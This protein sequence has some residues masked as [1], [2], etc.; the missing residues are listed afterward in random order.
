MI[1]YMDWIFWQNIFDNSTTML[2]TIQQCNYNG[3]ELTAIFSLLFLPCV[4]H[5]YLK[6]I[7]DT[8]VFS[9]SCVQHQKVKVP[10]FYTNSLSVVI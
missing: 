6:C 7:S 3:V 4:I 1:L 9:N 2:G 8:Y 10:N 5:I